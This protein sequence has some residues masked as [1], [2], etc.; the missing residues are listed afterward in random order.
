MTSRTI[1]QKKLLEILF[2]AAQCFIPTDELDDEQKDKLDNITY[3]LCDCWRCKKALTS[4]NID[5]KALG[6]ANKRTYRIGVSRD[7][8]KLLAGIGKHGMTI[9]I[10]LLQLMKTILHE[11]IHILF[12]EYDEEKVREKTNEWLS[13]FDWAE[14]R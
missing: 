4:P 3:R 12:A 11:I 7:A 6:H 8:V 10:F 1:S 5:W 14:V 2:E 13:S 9:P